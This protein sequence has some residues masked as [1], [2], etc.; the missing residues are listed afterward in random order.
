MYIYMYNEYRSYKYNFS[1]TLDVKQYIGWGRV[2]RRTE[3]KVKL[4]TKN[5]FD[6]TLA[7]RLFSIG[8]NTTILGII[9]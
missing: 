6:K 3:K 1:M 2:S 4:T 7:S 9:G 5:S 8:P